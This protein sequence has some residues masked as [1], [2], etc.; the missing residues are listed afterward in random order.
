MLE[1]MSSGERSTLRP[2]LHS[3]YFDQIPDEDKVLVI[4]TL[5]P[6]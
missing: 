5:V 4:A 2:H 1:A 3:K 6:T